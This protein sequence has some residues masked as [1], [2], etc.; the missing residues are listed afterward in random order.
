MK[1]LIRNRKN[2]L[3]LID[4]EHWTAEREGAHDFQS[5]GKA[6][7]F[8]HSRGL[9]EVEAVL[10]FDDPRFDIS[11][12]LHLRPEAPPDPSSGSFLW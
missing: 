3:Y 7:L 11:L 5:S 1:V 12:A 9:Q 6:I 8:A 4:N 2:G 10:A